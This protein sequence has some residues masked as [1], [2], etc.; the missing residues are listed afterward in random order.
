[1]SSIRRF[2]LLG[3]L[4]ALTLFSF[5]AALRG[6][7]SSMQEADTLFD[8]QLLDLSQLVANL[9]VAVVTNDFRLGNNLAFQVWDQQRLLAASHHAPAEYMTALQQGFDYANFDSYRWRTYTRFDEDRQHWVMVAERT[10]LRFVLAES[11]VLETVLPILL[12]IPLT[13]LLIWFVVSRGLQ[14]LAKLSLVLQH[15]PASD[16]SPLEDSQ[17][18][19]ELKPVVNAVNGLIQRLGAALE[20]EKRLS[21]DA[22]HELRTPIAAL[23]IQLHNV[24]QEVD[25]GSESFQQLQQGVDRMQHLVEQLMALYRTSPE[26]FAS[27]CTQLDLHALAQDVV[28]RLYPLFDAKQQTVELLGESNLLFGE[29]FALE[30]LL[31]N[32]LTNASKY[33][34]VAGKIQVSVTRESKQLVLAVHDNGPGIGEEDHERIFER[35][36]RVAHTAGQEVPGCGLGLTIVQHVADLHHAH[37]SLQP[38]VFGQGAAFSV[39]F[40]VSVREQV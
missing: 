27:A 7:Q 9:D 26:R 30:T 36:Y 16:L 24:A 22:A 28:A 31:T 4:S 40:P 12:G 37:V 35:F 21:A 29:R 38:S 10:D 8:S 6:Y 2:L 39:S 18:P 14:P 11:V 13:G 34:P 5:I 33:T 20:R 25:V 17:S 3:V 19:N 15:K 23:K 1:M 32:L